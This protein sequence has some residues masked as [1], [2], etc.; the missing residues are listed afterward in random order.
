MS[1]PRALG[2]CFY[3]DRLPPGQARRF[4]DELG[5]RPA[6]GDYLALVHIS[7]PTRQ[8]ESSYAG[9]CLKKKK[10]KK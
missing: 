10:K 1:E 2:R 6:G 5:R 9:F 3:R 7:E 4:Y 8:A